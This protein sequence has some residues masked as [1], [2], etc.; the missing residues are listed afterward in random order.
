MTS[1]KRA[2]IARIMHH[3]YIIFI[4]PKRGHLVLQDYMSFEKS[5]SEGGFPLSG[6]GIIYFSTDQTKNRMRVTFT[7]KGLYH[8]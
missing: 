4:Y 7:Y 6:G 1:N 3:L 8:N 5:T 2:K